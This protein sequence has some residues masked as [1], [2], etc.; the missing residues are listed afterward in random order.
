MAETAMKIVGYFMVFFIVAIVG[1][2][3]VSGHGNYERT[4]S[5]NQTGSTNKNNRTDVTIKP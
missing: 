2:V 3:W 5:V 4:D 1:C